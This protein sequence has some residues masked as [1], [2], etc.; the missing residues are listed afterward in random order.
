MNQMLDVPKE[1]RLAKVPKNQINKEWFNYRTEPNLIKL[2]II[3]LNIITLWY[4][5]T[6]IF[7]LKINKNK[8]SFNNS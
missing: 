3:F 1:Y 8:N 7:Y 2:S 4:F 5:V 6:W